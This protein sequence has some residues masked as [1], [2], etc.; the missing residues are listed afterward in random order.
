VGFG[1]A[2]CGLVSYEIKP[3][4]T[5]D[6]QWGGQGSTVVGTEVARKR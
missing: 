6:G 3:D 2:K 5:L 4:G 1:G